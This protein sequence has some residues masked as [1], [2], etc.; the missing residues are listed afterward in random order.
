MDLTDMWVAIK[1]VARIQGGF[2]IVNNGRVL[3][4]L[5]L[6]IAG[7]MSSSSADKVSSKLKKLLSIYH[8][9]GGSEGDPFVKLLF[10]SLPVIPE[11]K[12]TNKGYVDVLRGRL[13]DPIIHE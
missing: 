8:K 6:N 12:L 4:S 5:R 3:G 2:V 10:I 9:I 11:L 7:L 13:I 1:E